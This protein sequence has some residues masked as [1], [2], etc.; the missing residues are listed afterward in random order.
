MGDTKVNLN[1]NKT[2]INH[3][4]KQSDAKVAKAIS[5]ME[6]VEHWVVDD[7]ES[8]A[9]ELISLGKKMGEVSKESLNENAEEIIFI[10][11]Y[12]SCGKALRLLNWI[13]ATYPSLSFY[14]VMNARQT[15]EESDQARLLID[16][17]Q[18]IKILSMLGKVFSP[19][20]TRLISE[21]LKEKNSD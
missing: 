19:A 9:K 14:Y 8:V 20:R 13:D 11:A 18:T 1:F 6:N 15:V 10:M 5:V 3:F 21:L 2:T 4:W 16:R 7:V 17:L 12:I